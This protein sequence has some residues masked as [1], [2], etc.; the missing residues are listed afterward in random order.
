MAFLGTRVACFC[1]WNINRIR[2]KWLLRLQQERMIEYHMIPKIIHFC[3]FSKP[4]FPPDVRQCIHTWHEKLPDYEI[5]L[6]NAENFD[7]NICPYVKEAFQEKKYAFASDY[8]RLW[9]LYHFG[10]IYLDSDIE[11]VKAFDDLLDQRA[12]TGFEAKDSV[13]AWLLASE[14]G[15][16]LFKT[17][18]DDYKGRH[19]IISEGQYDTTPNPVAIRKRLV[20]H[21]LLLN[22]KTQFLDLITVYEETYFCPFNP[23]RKGDD[24][25]SG[26]TYANHHFNG[27]W[28]EQ[29]E[30]EKAYAKV[31]K[32]YVRVFGKKI[33]SRLCSM[34]YGIRYLGFR[35]WCKHFYHVVIRYRDNIKRIGF[36]KWLKNS[37]QRKR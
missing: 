29:S 13:A 31:E 2:Q 27:A 8:V 34:I 6:W 10:G 36:V 19:F 21:G 28:K 14:K 4:D 18:M 7:V 9:V 11:V 17:L 16:P 30:K 35:E 37:F 1:L 5:K 25:F 3:W 33:G 23:Y 20:E 12:F 32:K 15:N 24:C 22:G 26:K